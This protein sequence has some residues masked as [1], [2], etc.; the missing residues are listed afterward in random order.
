MHKRIGPGKRRSLGRPNFLVSGVSTALASLLLILCVLVSGCADSRISIDALRDHEAKAR[1]I[2]PRQIDTQQLSLTEI[3]EYTVGKGDVLAL[4]LLGL[5]SEYSLDE[6]LARV[7]DDGTIT[8]PLVGKVQVAGFELGHAEEVIRKAYI[9]DYVKNL[10]VY[11][12]IANANMT[13]V[14]VVGAAAQPGVVTLLRNELNVLYALARSG[15]FGPGSS[16]RVQLRPIRSDRESLSFD[17]TEINDLRR[18]L[19]APPLESGDLI[20]VEAAESPAVYVTGLVNTAGPVAIPENGSL[21]VLR[22]I[23][24]TGGIREYMKVKEATL[25]RRLTNGEQV[26]VKL[27]LGEMLAGKVEDVELQAG[28]ILSIAHT[29]ATFVQDW[30]IRSVI[31]GPT[32]IGVRY[33]PL[34]QYNANRALSSRFLSGGSLQSSIRASLGSGIPSILIPPVPVPAQP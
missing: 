26:H 4:D 5:Q 11:V 6:I 27:E 16:G 19:L 30:F 29:P 15:G 21:S 7:H 18:A 2:E 28:D 1:A 14:V 33:D 13:T 31:F 8:L 12:E 20:F 10:A 22:A 32:S 34:A 25:I 24:A 9:P 23:A 3:K 17:L